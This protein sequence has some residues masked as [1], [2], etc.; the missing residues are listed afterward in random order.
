MIISVSGIKRSGS[1]VQ[2][3][4]IRLA[5]EMS[6]YEVNVCGHSYSVREPKKGSVDLV[7]RHKFRESIAESA[8]HIFLTDRKDKD[9]VASAERFLERPV[10]YM[11]LEA[12]RKNYRLW[13]QYN[14]HEFHYNDWLEDR[15]IWVNGVIG[16]LGVDVAP[17]ELLTEFEKIKQPE[18]G[19]DKTTLLF[20]NHITQ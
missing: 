19:Q 10:E 7:K 11:E 8:S 4:L 18:K 3:N 1:T 12:W 5:L 16:A 14:A 17:E 13:K 20:H 2:F 15:M 9:V 6:G